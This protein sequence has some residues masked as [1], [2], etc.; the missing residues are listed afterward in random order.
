MHDNA[1]NKLSRA[2]IK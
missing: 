1:W 2:A